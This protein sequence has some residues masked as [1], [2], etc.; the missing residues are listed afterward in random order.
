VGGEPTAPPRTEAERRRAADRR[1][2]LFVVV[3]PA[4]VLGVAAF[5]LRDVT[6]L[7]Y[8]IAIAQAAA[9]VFAAR[10]QQR[11]GARAAETG[12][13]RVTP[14]L[15]GRV[16]LPSTWVLVIIAVL[17][18][19]PVLRWWAC[20]LF[21]LT[22]A[23]WPLVRMN[24]ARVEVVRTTDRRARVDAPC[25]LE[26]RV[27]H[28]GRRTARGLV[29]DDRV[30][31]WTRPP[32]LQALF[33]RVPGGGS[34]TLRTNVVMERRGWKRF[35]PVRLSTRF[36]L[37]FFEASVDLSAPCE[38]LVRPREGRPTAAL[39]ARLRGATVE[40]AASNT[41]LGTDEFHGLRAWRQGDDPRRIHWRTSARRGTI[42]YV[43]RRDEGFGD[44]VVALARSPAR[45]AE[46]DRRFEVAVP[47]AARS[48]A[49][50]CA[51]T[52][53]CGCARRARRADPA[54]GPR[55]WR[56]RAG[57]RRPLGGEGRRRATPARGPGRAHEA[58]AGHR[59]VGVRDQ[60]R[61]AAA[62]ARGGRR[63]GRARAR[64]ERADARAVR[65]GGPMTPAPRFAPP[66]LVPVVV[67]A[68]AAAALPGVPWVLFAAVA[69]AT[70]V[71]YRRSAHP[72]DEGYPRFWLVFW[73]VA[74]CCAATVVPILTQGFG[75]PLA[76]VLLSVG[77]VGL[78]AALVS[79][80]TPAGVARALA[81]AVAIVTGVSVAAPGP[82]AVAAGLAFLW[83]AVPALLA[84]PTDGKT[85]ATATDGHV[86][87][88][89]AT[90]AGRARCSRAGS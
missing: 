40:Q 35:R 26:V 25:G 46:A 60:R 18:R 34:V 38:V 70:V 64:V 89:H 30:G 56:P 8:G 13:P 76:P 52:C 16:A 29:V 80:P 51:T 62:D 87:R 20:V 2:L 66:L 63:A 55:P 10:R 3:I 74:P 21:G 15:L 45:G 50:R 19:E 85:L 22:L 61:V 28:R 59:R 48:S 9:V 67:A 82:Y 41:Q 7:L 88:L 4:V 11:A 58:R 49:R 33:D 39:L 83:T 75:E 27:E 86:R 24:L 57:P 79:P 77:L 47:I 71:R 23:A 73:T 32:A 42:T 6:S 17:V 68:A 1:T 90:D 53:G 31:P 65:A 36:P 72:R 84:L 14:T 43:E 69:V 5:F 54:A 12:V 44:V 78:A 37:G 81:I